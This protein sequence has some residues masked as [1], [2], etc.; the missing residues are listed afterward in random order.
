MINLTAAEQNTLAKYGADKCIAAYESALRFRA[1]Q[2]GGAYGT[3]LNL[4]MV[5][6]VGRKL[7]E[8]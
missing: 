2:K 6:L 7:K 3:G 1:Q 4:N 5:S 8:G